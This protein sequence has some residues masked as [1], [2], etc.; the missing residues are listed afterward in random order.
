L[1]QEAEVALQ[2]TFAYIPSH[3]PSEERGLACY[4]FAQLDADM[5][6][7][8]DSIGLGTVAAFDF[9]QLGAEGPAAAC[10]AQVGLL[11][12]EGGDLEHAAADLNRA[13]RF[14]DGSGDPGLAPSH[15]ARVL[16]ALA[17]AEA[18]LGGGAAGGGSSAARQHLRRARRLYRLAPLPGE[19][20]EHEWREAKVAAAAGR[21]AEAEAKLDGV[22]RQLLA[23]GSL[24][25][26]ARATFDQV[27][28][29][30]DAGNA[31]GVEELAGD[32][33]GAFPGGAAGGGAG[34]GAG[35]A[36]GGGGLI[37]GEG[38]RAGEPWA[39][40]IAAIGRLAGGPPGELQAAS[41]W[42]RR[43]LRFQPPM[44][45]ERPALIV[46]WRTLTDRLLRGYGEAGGAALRQAAGD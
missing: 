18:T 10:Y 7:Q 20:V 22:R 39:W 28:L 5:Q 41:T 11:Q 8:E 32:L 16:L 25:E 6:R 35:G 44:S 34:D 43:R 13:L 26:A 37:G 30:L 2:V 15:T 33:E 17:E 21:L 46:P 36:Q 27:Q 3:R 23:A 31:D 29:R 45:P 19:S 14:L 4:A 1:P 42:L 24:A 40:T 38:E 12:Q 9:F